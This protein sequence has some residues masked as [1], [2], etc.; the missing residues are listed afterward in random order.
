MIDFEDKEVYTPLEVARILGLSLATVQNYMENGKIESFI[1]GK[2][3]R[4]IKKEAFIAYLKENNLYQE[5]ELRY[6]ASY[7]RVSTQ[8]QSVRGD[9]Q[10]QQEKINN[11][12]IS[13]S[14]KALQCFTDVGS[15]LN[16]NRKGLNTLL[17]KVMNDEVDRI[18]ILH[19][20]R[21]TRFG[22]NYIKQICDKHNT[23]IV[24]LSEESQDKTIEQELAEDIITIIHSFS[25]KLYGLRKTVKEEVVKE[26][27]E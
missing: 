4:R 19:K 6:D 23:Q 2:R 5:K 3:N 13:K 11:A 24:V 7:A 10:R 18:F 21:L 22:F 26:L 14:P 17:Q 1:P 27:A 16:D 20:D 25:G 9:L 15:G 8:K 12:I